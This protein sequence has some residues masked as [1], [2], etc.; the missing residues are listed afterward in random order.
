MEHESNTKPPRSEG[1]LAPVIQLKPETTPKTKEYFDALRAAR[2][3][4]VRASSSLFT[5]LIQIACENEWRAWSAEQ[6]EGTQFCFGLGDFEGLDDPNIQELL[7][8]YVALEDEAVRLESVTPAA[9]R[10]ERR[11]LSMAVELGDDHS[12]FNELLRQRENDQE[13]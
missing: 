13:Q 12:H 7:A 4:V 2:E 3:E 1:E 10:K 5:S 8:V 11:R 6:P 9:P